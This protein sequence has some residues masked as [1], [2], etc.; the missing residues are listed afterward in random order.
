MWKQPYIAVVID[1]RFGLQAEGCGSTEKDAI[2]QARKMTK[3][4]VG[5][6]KRSGSCRL[7]VYAK[8]QDIPFSEVDR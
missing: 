6:E 4:V 5:F 2:N 7:Y 3:H 1:P 8:V